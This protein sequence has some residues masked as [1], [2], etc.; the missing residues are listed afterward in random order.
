MRPLHAA[1]FAA[2]V[3]SGS[4]VV[5]VQAQSH[6][7]HAPV[8]PAAP[9]A[10]NAAPAEAPHVFCPTMKT[11]QL[12]SHGTADRLSLLEGPKREQWV[13]AARRYNKAVDA[14]TATLM[15]ESKAFLTPEEQKLVEGW[16]TKGL[17]N[18]QINRLL[19]SQ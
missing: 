16:F 19:A 6:T 18:P 1:W 3:L 12:C 13:A 10:E 8:A 9:A 11:G 4:A 2:V 5:F 14:A 15:E 17:L 7:G